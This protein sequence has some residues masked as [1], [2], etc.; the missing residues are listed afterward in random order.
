MTKELAPKVKKTD[1]STIDAQLAAESQSIKEQVS[2][3]GGGPKL[4]IGNSG[5]WVTPDG[6]ELSESIRVVVVDFI[7]S[8]TWYPHPYQRGNPLPPGCFAVGKV[9]ANMAPDSSSPEMQNPT[10]AGCPQNEWGS[11][12]SG[13]GKACTQ[14]RRLAVILEEQFEDIENA[15]I[16]IVEITPSSI[17]HFDTFAR[18]AEKLLNGPPIKATVLMT[19]EQVKDARYYAVT[20]SDIQ[21]NENYAE[22]FQLRQEAMAMLDVLP[23]TT[24]YVRSD[25]KPGKPAP[26]TARR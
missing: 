10:C 13:N 14:K 9:I 25:E 12:A 16:F 3:G 8:H 2:A 26:A 21:P 17:K 6:L 18:Q 22:H 1:L 5:R 4:T 23:D 11:A 7:T 19:A 24:G 20:F 15:E